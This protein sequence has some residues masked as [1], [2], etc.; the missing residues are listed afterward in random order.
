MSVTE[1]LPGSAP[2]GEEDKRHLRRCFE[3]TRSLPQLLATLRSRRVAYGYS[4]ESGPEEHRSATGRSIRQEPGP[5]AFASGQPV[6]P[7]IR[8]HMREWHG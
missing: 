3:P 2:V 6:V 5:L 7:T 1:R 8:R 4:I